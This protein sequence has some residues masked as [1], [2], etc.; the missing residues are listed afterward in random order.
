MDVSVVLMNFCVHVGFIYLETGMFVVITVLSLTG[1]F[2]VERRVC[3]FDSQY[4][5]I[6]HRCVRQPFC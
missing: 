6:N 1:I 2:N 4:A 3:V 5:L